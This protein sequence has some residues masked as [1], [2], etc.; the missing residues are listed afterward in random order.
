M[1][2]TRGL[3]SGR[4]SGLV[5]RLAVDP[6]IRGREYLAEQPGPYLFVANHPSELDA[7]LLRQ[8][9]RDIAPQLVA[10]GVEPRFGLQGL[11]DRARG[12]RSVSRLAALVQRGVSVLLFPERHRSD[13]GSMTEF[14]LGAARLGIRSGAAIVP[15]ALVGTFRAQP[16]WRVVPEAGRPAVTVVF[17]KPIRPGA[18][19]EPAAVNRSIVEA[20]TLGMAEASL[21]WYEALR[22]QADHTLP[23]TTTDESAAHW[24]RVWNATKPDRQRRRQVWT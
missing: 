12:L 8:V 11:A 17:G 16:P 4:T 6:V 22:A 1:R 15:V 19:D 5:V 14:D 18:A 9:L 13:D 2:R 7:P 21:G 20:I 10:V 23:E 3:G 24:R